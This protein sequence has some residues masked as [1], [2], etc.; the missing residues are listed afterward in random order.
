MSRSQLRRDLDDG[1][2]LGL[3]AGAVIAIVFAV[4][5]VLGLGVWGFQVLTAPAKGAGDQRIIVNRAENRIERYNH[6]FDLCAEVQSR[7]AA[8]AA[9]KD[10]PEP[11]D[12]QQQTQRAANIVALTSTR[13]QL[14]NQY[15]A[16]ARKEGTGAQFR[17]SSLPYSL[18]AAQEATTCTV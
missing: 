11:A 9:L 5:A 15:N 4:I 3:G 1:A 6:F 16:D 8:L 2:G 18:D 17:D 13:S 12:A 10:S 7:E 14:I